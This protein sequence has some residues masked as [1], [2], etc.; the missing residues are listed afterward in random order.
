[1]YVEVHSAAVLG[2]LQKALTGDS[3]ISHHPNLGTLHKHVPLVWEQLV[4]LA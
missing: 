4:M 1:M 2:S 3:E